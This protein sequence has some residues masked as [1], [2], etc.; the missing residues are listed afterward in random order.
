[1]KGGN[2]LYGD[3]LHFFGTYEAF[4]RLSFFSQDGFDVVMVLVAV[5]TEYYVS[6][7]FG[8]WNADPF[9]RIS[10][11]GHLFSLQFETC[12]T[13]PYHTNQATLIPLSTV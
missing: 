13:V 12:M 4:E 11:D 3:P 5:G 6:G 7:C 2:P 10:H 9:E 8:L 1:V